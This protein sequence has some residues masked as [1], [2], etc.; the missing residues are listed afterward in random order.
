MNIKRSLEVLVLL[1]EFGVVSL[2]LINL[3]LQRVV[4][5]KVPIQLIRKLSQEI[6]ILVDAIVCFLQLSLKE[7]ITRFL[8]S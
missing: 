8:K 1:L 6:F 2:H 4:L 5:L 3:G 7:L